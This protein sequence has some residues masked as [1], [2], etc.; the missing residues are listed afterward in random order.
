MLNLSEKNVCLNQIAKDKQQAIHYIAKGLIENGYVNEGYEA[1]ILA[2]ETQTS[3][4]LGNGIAIPHGTLDT[5]DLVLKTGVQVYQF[6]NGIDWGQG[7]IAYV[8]I[9]IAAKSDEHLNLLRQLTSILSDEKITELLAKTDNLDQ[10]IGLLTGKSE[11]P[12]FS[13]ELISLNIETESLLTL[14][15]INATK[16][17][18]KAYVNEQF[19]TEVIAS[20]PLKLTD[21]LFVVDSNKGNQANGI[22]IARGLQGKTLITLSMVDNSLEKLLA[23]LLAKNFCHQLTTA[24]EDQILTLLNGENLPQDSLAS[25]NDEVKAGE[26]EAT[27]VVKN[28]HGLHARPSAILVNEVKKY[29]AVIQVQNLDRNSALVSAKSLMKIV[30]LGVQKGHRLRFVATGEDAEQAL[31]GIGEAISAGLGEH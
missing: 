18:E 4:F 12:S 22:A 6:P 20:T 13:K 9:G 21:N 1:G 15:A 31:Q 7:N 25:D 11:L 10:F 27:F 2:R 29:K 8:V 30:A 23:K 26:L 24:A 17:Q 14:S 16:L 19:V 3:T 28:E 5:R